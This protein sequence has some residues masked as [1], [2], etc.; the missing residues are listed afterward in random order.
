[1]KKRVRMEA[2]SLKTWE[3]VDQSLKEIADAQNEIS[4]IE[5]AMNMQIDA[6]K[7]VNDDKIKSYRDEI[8][9]QE[10]L[11]KE[12]TTDYKDDLKGRSRDLT[13]GKVGFRK[14]TRLML[15]KAVD[16]VIKSLRKNDMSDC[17]V[18]KETVNKDVLKTYDEKDILKVG[19]S[20]KVEDTFWYETKQVSIQ[21]G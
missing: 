21:E 17:I 18:V 20:L 16:K 11:I 2:A 13:F 8:K 14:S 6:I 10:L 12:Y 3:E 19:G 9:K 7:S 5:S 15:P 1:M 4:I